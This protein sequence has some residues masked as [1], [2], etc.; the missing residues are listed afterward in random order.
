M[1]MIKNIPEDAALHLRFLQA[2]EKALKLQPATS[3]GE[4]WAD[5]A[6]KEGLGQDES[7]FTPGFLLMQLYG[8]L[9]FSWERLKRDVKKKARLKKVDAQEWGNFSILN[10]DP[11]Y[12]R[13]P[14]TLDVVLET[15]RN[16]VSH[17]RVKLDEEGNITF[18]VRGG[19]KLQFDRQGLQK[20]L[21]SFGEFVARSSR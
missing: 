18:S 2:L 4:F 9:V 7:L 6:N 11:A 21:E 13:K 20:F 1:I 10:M 19:T 12:A 16:A 15:L 3:L 8:Q 14:L 5:F 17:A